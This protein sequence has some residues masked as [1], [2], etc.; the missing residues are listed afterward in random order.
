M[1]YMERLAT[2][3]LNPSKV[4]PWARTVVVGALSYKTQFSPIFKKGEV[5]DDFYKK[6]RF[7]CYSLG[8]DYH[9]LIKKSLKTLHGLIE[10]SISRTVKYR[11][12]VDTGP[13]LERDYAYMAGI[14]WIGKNTCII[15]PTLGSYL[16]L[17]VMLLDVETIDKPFQMADHCGS[18]KR[19]IKACPTGALK[20]AYLLDARSCI[21]YLNIEYKNHFNAL[22]KSQIGPY[23]VG[24]DICQAVCPWNVQAPFNRH[25]ELESDLFFPNESLEGLMNLSEK[26]YLYRVQG[27]A[28]KRVSYHKFVRNICAVKENIE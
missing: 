20:E 11:M 12:F 2:T 26:Q 6:P 5:M 16:F 17:G 14:G 19:C 13:M 27:K 28:I 8:M 24:C 18:C 23:V 21:S 3:R 4:F 7:S 9:K 1:G 15:H 10:K 25:L 22:E